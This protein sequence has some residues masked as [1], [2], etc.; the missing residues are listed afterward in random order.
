MGEGDYLKKIS[1]LLCVLWMSFIFCMSSFSGEASNE[2]SYAIVNA[3]RNEYITAK[4]VDTNKIE[5]QLNNFIKFKIG[6]VCV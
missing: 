2:K 6:E 3:A 5:M 4:G 1:I